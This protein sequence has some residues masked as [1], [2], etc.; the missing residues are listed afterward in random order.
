MKIG[1]LFALVV[2][3]LILG[4]VNNVFGHG[5]I[6]N[7][8]TMKTIVAEPSPRS[9]LNEI[10]VFFY[11][12]PQPLDWSSPSSLVQSAVRNTLTPVWG[13]REASL[14]EQPWSKSE[15]LKALEKRSQV[16]E[17]MGPDH[18]DRGLTFHPHSISHVN[19]RVHC[20]GGG[21][22]ILGS[23]S[24]ESTADYLRK[25]LLENAAL[26]TLVENVR[27]SM[28][29]T[30]QVKRWL[31]LMRE[32]GWVHSVKYKVSSSLCQYTKGFLKSFRE[33]G[34]SQI[35]G[36]LHTEPLKGVGAGCSAFGMS[37]LKIAGLYDRVFDTQ[38]VRS[39]KIPLA[40]MNRPGF[41]SRF[42]F[43]DFYLGFGP[44][45][46]REGEPHFFISFWDPQ[47]MYEWVKKVAQGQGHWYRDYR[48]EKRGQ[49]YV[50]EVD[51]RKVRTP[52]KPFSF[53][54]SH[55]NRI[56]TEVQ[57]LWSSL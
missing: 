25:L 41:P 29:T 7:L 34:Q 8:D 28:Y 30:E 18:S 12:A 57:R 5:L 56:Q 32:R 3:I 44:H 14:P 27:G 45:W 2:L 47:L 22:D 23:T 4:I 38:F 55:R 43:Y 21:E 1:I 10:E 20:E 15:L 54:N 51:A 40:A 36:G 42:N 49:S 33:S 9:D 37:V 16:E 13:P 17:S 19:V 48:V 24:V 46:A 6:T 31:P 39:L 35:Y 11:S 52:S 50:L 53:S 26:E